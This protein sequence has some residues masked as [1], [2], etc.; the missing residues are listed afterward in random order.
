[1]R[2][3]YVSVQASIAGVLKYL[4]DYKRSYYAQARTMVAVAV[5]KAEGM[6]LH[7]VL[8]RQVDQIDST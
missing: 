3:V 6:P 4:S 7:T 5:L 1:M 8:D 2:L